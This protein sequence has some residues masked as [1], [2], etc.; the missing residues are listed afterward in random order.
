MFALKIITYRIFTY[1]RL[2][3]IFQ[4]YKYIFPI[5]FHNRQ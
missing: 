5:F 1:N 2:Q 3:Y 4:I